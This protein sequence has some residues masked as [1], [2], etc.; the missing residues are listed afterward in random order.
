MC[1]D[2]KAIADAG[3]DRMIQGV[4]ESYPALKKSVA[5][6]GQHAEDVLTELREIIVTGLKARGWDMDV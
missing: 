3:L 2:D 5:A 6:G 4:L 1:N